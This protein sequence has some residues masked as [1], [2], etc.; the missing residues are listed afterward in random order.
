LTFVSIFAVVLAFQS[1]VFAAEYYVPD[2]FPTIQAALDGAFGGDTVIVRDGVWRGNGNKY[3]DFMG[4]A[5]TLR[6]ENGP[7]SCVIDCENNGRGFYFHSGEISTSIV[8]GFSIIGG[9][10]SGGGGGIYCY[11]SSPVI[12]NCALEDNKASYGG[13]IYCYWYSSPII[14][15][16]DIRDN[17]AVTG[18]GVYFSHASAPSIAS[19]EISGNTAEVEAGGIYCNSKMLSPTVPTMTNCTI[20][21]NSAGRRGGGVVCDECAP[22]IT[23]CTVSENRANEYAGGIYCCSY[24]SPTVVNC[25]IW[26]N[27][28]QTQRP[29]WLC[30]TWGDIP[31][32]SLIILI[33]R[34]GKEPCMPNPIADLTA[35]KAISMQIL[36]L[37]V[38]ETSTC[39]SNLPVSM[40]E[41]PTIFTRT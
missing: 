38:R 4:K 23:N 34:A 21:G 26:N 17:S 28:A 33:S 3:L 29:S 13:G 24:A 5:I 32:S 18:A 11:N 37:S 2:N 19:C 40:R 12:S 20:T 1:M 25:I 36:N 10:V 31:A 22:K 9:N 8:R 7:A 16:C 14:I 27:E 30:A 39:L 41:R 15:G 6:S 35:G